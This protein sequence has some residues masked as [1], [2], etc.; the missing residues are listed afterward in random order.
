MIKTEKIGALVGVAEAAELLGWDRRRVS[1]YI[2]K[3]LFP[4]PLQEL[5]CGPIW[6]RETIETYKQD[7]E[8]WKRWRHKKSPGEAQEEANNERK[9]SK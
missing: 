8:R 7:H 9:P 6:L 5:R 2:V 4:E 1:A 3:G